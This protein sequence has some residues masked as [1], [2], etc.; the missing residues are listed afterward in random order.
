MLLI[1]IDIFNIG[2]V[3][4]DADPFASSSYAKN[5]IILKYAD[6]YAFK[7]GSHK[8]F[9]IHASTDPPSSL[10]AQPLDSP[11]HIDLLTSFP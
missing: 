2:E 8:T 10:T 5:D 3:N 9:D 6:Q 11:I 4:S 7:I 1:Q